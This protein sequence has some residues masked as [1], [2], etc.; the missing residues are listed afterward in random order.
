MRSGSS[1]NVVFRG[2]ALVGALAVFAPAGARASG[3]PPEAA[4]AAPKAQ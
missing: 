1:V 2:A 3:E 4:P